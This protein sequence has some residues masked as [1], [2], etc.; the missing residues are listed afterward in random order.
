VRCWHRARKIDA[1]C[2]WN[3]ATGEH[4]QQTCH[5]LQMSAEPG[6]IRHGS[7]CERVICMGFS[8]L[9]DLQVCVV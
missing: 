5:A 3:D 6:Q 8:P 1:V 9:C 2:C 4:Q 7:M